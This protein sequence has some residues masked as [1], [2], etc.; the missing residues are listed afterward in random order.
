MM[1]CECALSMSD[2]HSI[3]TRVGVLEE[4]RGYLHGGRTTTRIRPPGKG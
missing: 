2:A 4:L 1:S 3:W